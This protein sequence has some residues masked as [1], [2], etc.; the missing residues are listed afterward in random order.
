MAVRAVVAPPPVNHPGYLAGQTAPPYLL[1]TTVANAAAIAA[2]DVVY[3]WMWM[4]LAPVTPVS[5]G[6]RVGVGGAGSAMKIGVWANNAG[7]MRPTS[8]PLVSDNTGVATTSNNTFALGSVTARTFSPGAPVWIGAKFTGTLP[9]ATQVGLQGDGA[10]MWAGGIVSGSNA[11]SLMVGVSAP[12]A[13]ANDIAALDLTS[14]TFT[15]VGQSAG[16]P[17]Y[18]MGT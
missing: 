3:L 14:A 15:L 2:V 16:M 8:V 7:T 12:D 11:G 18:F 6:I 10:R 5:F 17:A 1:S 9:T 13:Y 4:P